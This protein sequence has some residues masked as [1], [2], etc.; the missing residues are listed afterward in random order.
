VGVLARAIG[1]I[2]GEVLA[3]EGLASTRSLEGWYGVTINI[4]AA[5]L[6]G[7]YLYTTFV[8]LISRETHVSFYVVGNFVLCLL[9]YSPHKNSPHPGRSFGGNDMNGGG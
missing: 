8:G 6:S 7:F 9:L 2:R 1:V 3:G 4:S 5:L